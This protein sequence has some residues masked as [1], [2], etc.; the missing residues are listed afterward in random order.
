MSRS[1]PDASMAINLIATLEKI[2][3]GAYIQP[4]AIE[5]EAGVKRD[6]AHYSLMVVDLRKL[7]ETLI[8]S[9]T[10]RRYVTRMSKDGIRFL[11]VS[12]SVTYLHGRVDSGFKQAEVAHHKA[13]VCIEPYLDE[14]NENER[15]QY[16]DRQHLNARMLLQMKEI[17]LGDI[18]E[19]G[20]D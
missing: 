6:H 20:K 11:S 16:R 5:G 7:I 2:E 18:P 15:R 13:T 8:E 10:G 3:P 17:E 9:Q 4:G 1:K 12:E 19:L 14:L